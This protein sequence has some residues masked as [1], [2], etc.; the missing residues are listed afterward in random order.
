MATA[1][2]LS[3][4][5]R[6]SKRRSHRLSQRLSANLTVRYSDQET[7]NSTTGPSTFDSLLAI[8]GIRYDFDPM[9]F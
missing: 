2:V 6:G 9:Q 4:L 5:T 8:L 7:K 1:F 3:I